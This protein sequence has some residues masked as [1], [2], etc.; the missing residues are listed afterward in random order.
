MRSW[1]DEP[2]IGPL[3]LESTRGRWRLADPG[4]DERVAGQRVR[5]SIDS[6]RLNHEVDLRTVDDDVSAND[7]DQERVS[8]QIENA[9][10]ELVHFWLPGTR[11]LRRHRPSGGPEVHQLKTGVLY[12]G[13]YRT[14]VLSW[15]TFGCQEPASSKSA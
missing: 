1:R 11:Q 5:E 7:L 4:Q 10:F 2:R 3:E 8:T 12:L 15:C 14:P 6:A 9:G 13:G